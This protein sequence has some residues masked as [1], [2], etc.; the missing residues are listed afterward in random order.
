[1]AKLLCSCLHLLDAIIELHP[2]NVKC[3]LTLIGKSKW[4]VYV[5][6]ACIFCGSYFVYVEEAFM[7]LNSS[8]V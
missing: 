7:T 8:L 3:S 1:M 2:M 6:K 5:I 4:I